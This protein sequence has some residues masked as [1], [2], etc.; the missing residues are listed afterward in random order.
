MQATR[1][2]NSQRSSGILA[3]A[4]AILCLGLVESVQAEPYMAIREG[5]KCSTCH[6]N[7]TGG[8]MRTLL[9]NT[10]LEEITPE[11]TRAVATRPPQR[12]VLMQPHC[13]ASHR[14]CVG[15]VP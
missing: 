10:H 2:G 13:V 11:P 15:C 8:G 9:A 4:L 12:L 14:L 5:R 1:N 7:M 6:V 3:L